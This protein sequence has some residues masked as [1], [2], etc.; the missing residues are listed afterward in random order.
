[1]KLALSAA[2]TR[3]AGEGEV[4]ADA[5]RGAVDGGD[6][7]L[8]AVEDRGDQALRAVADH[9]GDLAGDP[10]GGAVGAGRE[11]AAGPQ[12]G[13]GAEALARGGQHHAA[14]GQVG[15][16][17]GQQ[18]DHPV[19]LVGGDGV[20]GLG[21]VERDPR[22]PVVDPVQDLVLE[23]A[24]GCGVAHGSPVRS[25]VDRRVYGTGT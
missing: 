3:S 21:P 20:V 19:A 24:F 10:L 25:C 2:M 12:V 17:V 14:H 7:R 1:M 23:R 18:A 16:G 4:G 22:H 9:A 5:G 13:A 8:L 15:A 11:R 6:H